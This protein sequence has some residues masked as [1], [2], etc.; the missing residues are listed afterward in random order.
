MG[1]KVKKDLLK[2]KKKQ[3]MPSKQDFDLA[4]SSSSKMAKGEQFVQTFDQILADISNEKLDEL[5]DYA[6]KDKTNSLKKLPRFA[7]FTKTINNMVKVKEFLEEQ[8]KYAEDALSDV[9]VEQCCRD[10][11]TFD[12]EQVKSIIDKT[13]GA[14][15]SQSQRTDVAM[16]PAA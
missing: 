6:H 15:Q 7:H 13:V 12:W 4:Q 5:S 3:P 16:K 14:R 1:G 8:I 9:I 2:I 11:D 10:D